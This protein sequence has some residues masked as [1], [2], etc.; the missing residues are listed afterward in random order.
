MMAHTSDGIARS[1]TRAGRVAALLVGALVAAT[2]V[3]TSRPEPAV[4]AQRLPSGFLLQDI[5]TGMAPPSS[6][7]PGDLLTDFD[8]MPVSA[9]CN[10]NQ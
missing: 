8:R 9:A 4:A 3:A 1:R 7:G 5:A 2:F 6:A 10:P